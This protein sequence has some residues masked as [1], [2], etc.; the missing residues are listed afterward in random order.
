MLE[1][2]DVKGEICSKGSSRGQYPN[3]LDIVTKIIKSVTPQMVVRSDVT[4]QMVK[5][6]TYSILNI[7]LSGNECPDAAEFLIT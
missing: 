5:C 2:P 6:V 3:V 7:F 1:P 4:P